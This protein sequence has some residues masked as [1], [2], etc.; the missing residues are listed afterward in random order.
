MRHTQS[1]QEGEAMPSPNVSA[2]LSLS[3]IGRGKTVSFKSSP[4]TS[5][6]L[7]PVHPLYHVIPTAAL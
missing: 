3:V 1:R 7:H 6:V 4:K 2:F 5:Y